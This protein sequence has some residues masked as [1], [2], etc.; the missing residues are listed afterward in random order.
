MVLEEALCNKRG[1][2]SHTPK[3]N[4]CP[5]AVTPRLPLMRRSRRTHVG[6]APAT[7]ISASDDVMAQ[8]AFDSS[9]GRK[10]PFVGLNC[11]AGLMM[12]R[13]EELAAAGESLMHA[14]KARELRGGEILDPLIAAMKEALEKKHRERVSVHGLA[15]ARLRQQKDENH[16]GDFRLA[17]EAAPRQA[18][19]CY[20]RQCA[21]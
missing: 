18:S 19:S 10:L 15:P 4:T 16:N 20:S 13:K 21:A 12:F 11:L 17:I 1:T 7:W 6:C 8:V 2:F 5:V 3:R 9:V 14:R